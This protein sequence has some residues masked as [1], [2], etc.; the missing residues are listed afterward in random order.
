MEEILKLRNGEDKLQKS[1]TMVKQKMI[2][3]MMSQR[4]WIA[5]RR[6]RIKMSQLY[7][8]KSIRQIVWMRV[9]KLEEIETKL[10]EKDKEKYDE[11]R[12]LKRKIRNGKSS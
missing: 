12:K 3:A 10:K 6:C 2:R 7:W 5:R 11:R 4:L 8:R 1:V 9:R